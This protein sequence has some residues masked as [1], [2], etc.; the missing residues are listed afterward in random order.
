MFQDRQEV[1]GNSTLHKFVGRFCLKCISHIIQGGP[2]TDINGVM[3]TDRIVEK[4]RSIFRSCF[5]VDEFSIIVVSLKGYAI[6]KMSSH[7]FFPIVSR[8]PSVSFHN[9][10][11]PTHSVVFFKSGW[12]CPDGIFH[13]Y[14]LFHNCSG[15][16]SMIGI[17]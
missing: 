12:F 11:L 7:T 14:F 8:F 10:I 9:C 5:A 13:N 3:V 4:K 15:R 6:T 2:L 1:E 16:K 17:M